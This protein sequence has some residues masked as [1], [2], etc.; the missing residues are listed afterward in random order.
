MKT[1]IN[2]STKA[3]YYLWEDSK[4]IEI[5]SDRVCVGN[6][7]ELNI[8]FLNSSNSE[9]VEGVNG[10]ADFHGNKY[11]YID[12]EWVNNHPIDDG[13]TYYWDQ[14]MWLW[15]GSDDPANPPTE[16]WKATRKI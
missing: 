14:D 2:K 5:K 9:I 3:A 4:N 11:K 7:V 8:L 6:P 15:E 12:G 13:V 10:P 16:Q 1:L